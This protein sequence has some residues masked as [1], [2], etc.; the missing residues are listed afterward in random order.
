MQ[1]T[2]RSFEI[3]YVKLFSVYACL[4]LDYSTIQL[5]IL[6]LHIQKPFKNGCV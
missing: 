2:I 5:N 6:T 1:L 3:F 4:L